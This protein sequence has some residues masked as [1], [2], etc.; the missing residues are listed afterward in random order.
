M[1]KDSDV[2]PGCDGSVLHAKSEPCALVVVTY[3][4]NPEHEKTNPTRLTPANLGRCI[5]PSFPIYDGTRHRGLS[6][7]P[8]PSFDRAKRV[9][10]G[11]PEPAF[12][13]NRTARRF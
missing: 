10:F 7:H 13:A 2:H 4:Q 6:I 1:S 12:D 9:F 8:F 3:V 5:T 11:S